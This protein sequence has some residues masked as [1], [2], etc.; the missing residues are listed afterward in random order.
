MRLPSITLIASALL[1]STSISWA[2]GYPYAVANRTTALSRPTCT[3]SA[4]YTGSWT[5]TPSSTCSRKSSFTDSR[6]KNDAWKE[7]GPPEATPIT[8]PW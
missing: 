8:L 6:A 1:L 7:A 2:A 4:T 3:W 5:T